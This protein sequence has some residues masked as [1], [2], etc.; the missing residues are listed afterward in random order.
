MSEGRL[1][2]NVMHFARL[3]RAAGLRIGP[4]RV[5]DCVR[6]LEI[7]NAA[8][9]PP[10]REDWYWTMSAVLLSRQEQRPIFDQA[11]QIFWRDPKLAERMMQ[12]LL[13]QVY[14]RAAPPERE[15][16][17]RLTDALMQQQREVREQ[18][19]ERIELDARLTF[20]SSE[21]LQRMDFDT[22]SAAELA[23]AKRM[24][25]ELRLP[26]PVIRTRRFRPHRSGSRVD[27]R[28]TLRESLREGGD[29][30]PLV[31]TTPRELH[32]PLVVLCDISGSMNPYARMFLHFLHAITN[33]RDR[34]TVF[35]FGTRL[36]NITRQ[37]RHRDV[38]V[39]MGRVADAIQDWSGGTRIGAS[40]R[41][42]NF[43]W[44]RR[45]LGQNACV[46]LVSDGLDREAGEGLSEEMERLAKSCRW[47]I[48][49]N[50][51]LRYEK[52]EARPAGVRAMLPHV[53]LFLPVH[54]LKTLIDLARTLNAGT[55]ERNRENRKWR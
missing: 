15:Q 37:L 34:V 36:T 7:A 31:R 44:G 20:S 4:D 13:P 11:F 18:Q 10:R 9:F 30:I 27:L 17:Q 8:Q 47:L 16:S 25:G 5:I 19:E 29:A 3:L 33:D 55:M 52:F 24:I 14:G 26:L 1:A 50:P 53:D 45:V 54:N 39:A 42:F 2:E 51:L 49:L 35:V 48:W 43:R 41:E 40:L 38:D 22:M 32:P 6:A 21:V 23:E 28:R 46:L 12:S